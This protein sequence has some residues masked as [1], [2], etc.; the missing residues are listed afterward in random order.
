MDS[1][2]CCLLNSQSLLK[3]F[4]CLFSSRE[5]EALWCDLLFL[6]TGSC[7]VN[8][9]DLE[10][11]ILPDTGIT[12]MHRF[13]S[14]LSVHILYYVCVWVPCDSMTPSACRCHKRIPGPPDRNHRWLWAACPVLRTQSGSLQEWLSAFSCWVIIS[15]TST[16]FLKSCQVYRQMST[17]WS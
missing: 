15:I 9:A 16:R 1:G 5:I 6:E 2:Y 10:L 4:I 7:C 8:Q 11:T 14:K 3:V 13:F 12:D 17:L